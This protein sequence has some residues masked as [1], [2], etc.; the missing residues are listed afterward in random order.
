VRGIEIGKIDNIMC[1]SICIRSE[2]W[3]SIQLIVAWVI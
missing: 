1:L 3:I 2:F